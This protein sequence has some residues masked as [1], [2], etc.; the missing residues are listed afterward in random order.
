[1]DNP[2][3]TAL[4]AQLQALVTQANAIPP[5]INQLPVL[6]QIVQAIAPQ[7]A[8]FC[9]QLQATA[10]STLL[11]AQTALAPFCDSNA[12]IA[13]SLATQTPA[14]ATAFNYANYFG[15]AV[16]QGAITDANTAITM[17]TAYL[18]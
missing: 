9:A 1:M 6:S 15:T 8:W 16:T 4:L 5:G 11:A 10:A 17:L 14:V 13:N 18:A 3:A 12:G 7:R 2:T